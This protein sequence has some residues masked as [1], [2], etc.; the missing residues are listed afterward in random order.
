MKKTLSILIS[1]LVTILII[2]G[3]LCLPEEWVYI[4]H[5]E[6]IYHPIAEML[7]SISLFLMGL[8]AGHGVFRFFESVFN[9]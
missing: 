3:P 4:K 8:F 7:F 2:I 9:D 6:S 1:S 5:N